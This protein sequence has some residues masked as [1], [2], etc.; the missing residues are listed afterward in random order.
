MSCAPG[1]GR[2][3][4]SVLLGR[5]GWGVAGEPPGRGV[6]CEPHAAREGRHDQLEV[7]RKSHILSGYGLHG[8]AGETAHAWHK[9]TEIGAFVVDDH[10]VVFLTNGGHDRL[11]E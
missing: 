2:L 4:T 6:I 5:S 8:G 7:A 9:Y 10:V 3:S 1:A 11:S